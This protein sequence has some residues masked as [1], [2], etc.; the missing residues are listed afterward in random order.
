MA[1]NYSPLVSSAAALIQKFG[2]QMTLEK[3]TQG[4]FNPAT[5]VTSDTTAQTT[6]YGVVLD[7]TDSDYATLSRANAVN[8]Y[9]IAYDKK[10]TAEA[11][12]YEVGDVVILDSQRYTIVENKPLKPGETNVICDLLVRV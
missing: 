11:G 4:V 9:V 12:D 3:T 7:A 10:I 8:D 1:F 5:G 6:F 2:R